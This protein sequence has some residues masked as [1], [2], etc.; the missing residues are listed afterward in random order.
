M[1]TGIGN[2]GLL[3]SKALI[4]APMALPEDQGSAIGTAILG[5]IQ[6]EVAAAAD[7]P[8]P[9][10]APL[11]IAAAMTIPGD[12]PGPGV[13]IAA[14]HIQAL[15]AD[16]H[17]LAIQTKALVLS[18]VAVPKLQLVAIAHATGNVE[19]FAIGCQQLAPRLFS[20]AGFLLLLLVVVVGGSAYGTDHHGPQQKIRRVQTLAPSQRK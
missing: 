1:L 14:G 2:P 13:A 16:L 10:P 9:L 17:R 6:T 12:H 15:A 19:A 20:L 5:Y 11:L 18:A 4:V 3:S 7:Q 8:I